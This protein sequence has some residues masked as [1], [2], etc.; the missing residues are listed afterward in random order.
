MS[1]IKDIRQRV[2]CMYAG[3]VFTYDM[4]MVSNKEFSATAKA[5]SR[6][7]KE[8]VIKRYKKGVY[9]KPKETIFGELKPSENELLK[10][11][12]L[13]K[14]K[15]IAYITGI[16]LY[17]ELGLTTQVPNTIRVASFNRRINAKV[18]NLEVTSV[19]SY[20]A[21]TRNNVH[22]LQLLDVIKDFK[23]IP[24][25]DKRK[26]VFFLRK[27]LEKLSP[28]EEVKLVNYAKKYPP[29]VGAFLG[30]LLEFINKRKYSYAITILKETINPSSRYE[31]GVSKEVIP[32]ALNWNIR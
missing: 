26:G 8:G 25:L 20:V 14:N 19:K 11:Y 4:L 7:V 16:R 2:S 18:G 5:L 29:K 3:E 21:I 9:Y 13:D 17:N 24:D 23:N 31:F 15:Q 32:S 1:R 27:Q 22:L 12:L 6:L 28:N 10:T 30:A